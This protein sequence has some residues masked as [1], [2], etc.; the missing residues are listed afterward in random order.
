[1]KMMMAHGVRGNAP[2]GGKW[3]IRS[4]ARYVTFLG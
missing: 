1:M 3:A 4:Y 2:L